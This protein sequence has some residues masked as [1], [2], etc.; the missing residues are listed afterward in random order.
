V[1]AERK[2]FFI[3]TIEALGKQ[4]SKKFSPQGWDEEDD[5]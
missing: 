2:K 3:R 1:A 5:Y 4:I